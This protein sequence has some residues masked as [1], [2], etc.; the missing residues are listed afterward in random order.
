MRL[1]GG[2]SHA[3][4]VLSGVSQDTVLGPLLFLILMGDINNG[5]SSSSIVSFANDT[6]LYHGISNVDDCSFLQHDLNSVYDWASC[7]NMSFN[8]QKLT[9]LTLFKALV[10]SRLDYG[11][12]LWSPYLI[13]HINMVEK[14]Q[15]SPVECFSPNSS[16]SSNV[17][18]SSSFDIINYSKNILDLGINVS[19]NCSFDFHISNLVK[20][21]KHLTGWILIT[22]SS[23]DKLTMLT[24]FKALVM[25]RL[26]Y[27]C[28]LWSPYLIKHINMVEKV[29]RSFTRFISGMAGLSYAERLTVL[30][31]YSLQ[32]R[33]ERYILL[34]MCGR[35]WRVWSLIFT[36]PYVL[37]HQI[38]NGKPL[39]R[40]T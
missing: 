29:Q 22:F 12:Q 38:V 2:I 24:L 17:Y 32:H 26:D 6:R 13:K 30:K 39:S 8:A 37:K 28:Q 7:K 15:R 16:S 25:S 40:H 23:R 36:L 3:S 19:S 4:P 33:R 9:M 34:F 18:I 1:Q 31:L 10:M 35:F 5:I 11:C 14:V 27:G 20:R 21:T